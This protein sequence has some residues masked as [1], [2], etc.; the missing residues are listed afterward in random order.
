MEVFQFP[1]VLQNVLSFCSLKEGLAL[2][3]VCRELDQLIQSQNN[4]WLENF[5]FVSCIYLHGVNMAIGTMYLDRMNDCT[6]QKKRHRKELEELQM[7]IRLLFSDDNPSKSLQILHTCCIKRYQKE[8]KIYKN[9]YAGTTK[10]VQHFFELENK[11][12]KK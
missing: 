3:L 9:L 10:R 4:W 8:R 7:P 5:G 2:R 12:N 1:P 11:L 6:F